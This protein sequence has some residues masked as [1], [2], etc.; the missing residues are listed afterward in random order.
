[1]A[2]IGPLNM[3]LYNYLDAVQGIEAAVIVRSDGGI[4]TSVIRPGF[5]EEEV[6]GL[7]EL[8]RYI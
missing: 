2:E 3:L 5:S 4:L 1:M 6:G 8:I 7:T